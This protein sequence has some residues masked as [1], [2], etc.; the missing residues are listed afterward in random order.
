[1]WSVFDHRMS[2]KCSVEYCHDKNW[3][4]ITFN[5]GLSGL[6]SLCL[7]VEYKLVHRTALSDKYQIACINT[8]Q[9]Q[10]LQHH[11]LMCVC[12][13]SLH[14]SAIATHMHKHWN[15]FTI[16]LLVIRFFIFFCF[17]FKVYITWKIIRISL[18]NS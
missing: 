9:S 7:V 4:L 1:M 3:E 10:T 12:V 6:E 5:I 16:V 8:H 17:G 18:I 2:S 13:C 15:N 11:S 14:W